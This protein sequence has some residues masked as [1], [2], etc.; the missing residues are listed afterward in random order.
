MAVAIFHGTSVA[1]YRGAPKDKQSLQSLPAGGW[2]P[3]EGDE[4]R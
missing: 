2:C 1:K 3:S 4:L